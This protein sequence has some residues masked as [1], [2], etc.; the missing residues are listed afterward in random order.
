MQVW[1]ECGVGSDYGSLRSVSGA[2]RSPSV[3]YGYTF[4]HTWDDGTRMKPQCAQTLSEFAYR[5]LKEHKEKELQR[6]TA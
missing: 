2:I 6:K 4:V 3:F 1:Q 5:R